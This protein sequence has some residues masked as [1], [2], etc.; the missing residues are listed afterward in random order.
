M[1]LERTEHIHKATNIWK[2]ILIH[3]G[4]LTGGGDCEFGGKKL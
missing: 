1:G 4:I 3:T 2:K